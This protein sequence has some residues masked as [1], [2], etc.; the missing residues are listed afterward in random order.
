MTFRKF[1][2]ACYGLVLSSA[3]ISRASQKADAK[4]PLKLPLPS[5]TI[6]HQRSR[7][8]VMDLLMTTQEAPVIG[9]T[10]K[11]VVHQKVP[12][13]GYKP[14]SPLYHLQEGKQDGQAS[15][16]KHAEPQNATRQEKLY[17]CVDRELLKLDAP[18]VTAEMMQEVQ[19]GTNACIDK[20]DATAFEA[21]AIR[22]KTNEAVLKHQFWT[23]LVSGVLF[24]IFT[25]VA[26]FVYQRNKKD[27]VPDPNRRFNSG[28]AR[29]KD[30]FTF[31]V[32]SFV[33]VPGMSLLTCCCF[34]IRW[35]DTM[36]MASYMS[37]WVG[38]ILMTL[39]Q[40]SNAG[41]AGGLG[42]VALG[43]V[44]YYRQKL[45]KDFGLEH[46]TMKSCCCDF[47]GYCWIPCCMAL[48]EAREL[49]EAYAVGRP[50]GTS[51]GQ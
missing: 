13:N 45:R 34:A 41:T 32:C 11:T 23:V 20:Y 38:V 1:C 47:C 9:K 6:V 40:M 36:R 26:A 3:T 10:T 51:H 39:L 12:G 17:A 37:F 35:A 28:M 27:P 18:E 16:R 48:Q 24:F 50:I 43:V 22:E 33:E 4:D 46:S 19:N 49:E 5:E 44:V 8:P 31:G 30:D 21:F 25:I 14:G 15:T 29:N 2:W 7:V 42:I